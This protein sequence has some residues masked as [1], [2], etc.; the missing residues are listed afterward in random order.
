MFKFGL[1]LVLYWN[2][3]CMTKYMDDFPVCL[4]DI[5]IKTVCIFELSSL[6]ACVCYC[7]YKLYY[8]I[9]I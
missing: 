8:K 4:F 9:Y 7:F 2:E 3:F 1:K 5:C 6:Y